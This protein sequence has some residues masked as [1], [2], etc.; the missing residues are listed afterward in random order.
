MLIFFISHFTVACTWL[1][2]GGN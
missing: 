2:R 1:R